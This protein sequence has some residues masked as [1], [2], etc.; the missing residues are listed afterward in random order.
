VVAALAVTA[1]TLPAARRPQVLG[2]AVAALACAAGVALHDGAAPAAAPLWG[3]GVLVAGGLAERALTLPDHGEIEVAAVVAW[4]AG[5]GAL[6]GAG[7]A[8]A[9]VVLLAAGTSVGTSVAGLVAGAL[10]AV[11]PTAMAR[12]WSRADEAR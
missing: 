11:L 4:L 9:A 12:R 5:L 6:A 10:L 1:V 2:V 8:A 7:L 3:A